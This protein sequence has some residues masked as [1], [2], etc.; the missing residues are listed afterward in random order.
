[1]REQSYSKCLEVTNEIEDENE[2][3]KWYL[4]CRFV[5]EQ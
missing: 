2:I 5:F 4:I 3:I 1:M